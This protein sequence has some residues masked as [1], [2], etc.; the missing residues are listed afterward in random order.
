MIHL[1][2]RMSIPFSKK[3]GKQ[4]EKWTSSAAA[5]RE[6]PTDDEQRCSVI[7]RTGI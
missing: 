1:L 5:W 2:Q 3:V 4:I 7:R 6:D